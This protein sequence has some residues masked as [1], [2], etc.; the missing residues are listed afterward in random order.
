MNELMIVD[1]H[2]SC[3]KTDVRAFLFVR[4]VIISNEYM[5]IF[6][7]NFLVFCFCF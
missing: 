6:L 4:M 5:I 3:D 2:N 7:F 1:I